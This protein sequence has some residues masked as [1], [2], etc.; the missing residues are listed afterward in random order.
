MLT[1]PA[2]M[3]PTLD[4][5]K[6]NHNL[7]E[8]MKF[9]SFNSANEY[10]QLMDTVVASDNG[11]NDND[12]TAG[13]LVCKDDG[14]TH[15]F[16]GNSQV[17]SDEAVTPDGRVI[18]LHFD[19]KSV[20]FLQLTDKGE[21]GVEAMAQHFDRSTGKGWMQ[22]GGAVTV[23]NMDEP[24]ALEQIFQ[25]APSAG[26]SAAEQALIDLLS[27]KLGQPVSLVSSE[28]KGFNAGDCG[29]PVS[30]ELQMSAWTDGLEV[31]LQAG[32]EKFIY[33]GMDEKTGRFGQDVDH[34]GYWKQDEKG[35]YRPDGSASLDSW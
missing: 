12:L 32:D 10:T 19:E 15:R 21:Q 16:T 8:G 24:G 30:G 17:G 14:E 34:Q 31:K 4:R 9:G 5:W 25:T 22:V 7:G 6:A 29:F 11:S 20:N 27:A 18:G 26:P 13:L 28:H 33:R 3:Q 1:V 23:I 2:K 35:I